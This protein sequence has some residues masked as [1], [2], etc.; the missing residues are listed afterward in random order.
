MLLLFDAHR[1]VEVGVPAIQ[2]WIDHGSILS[3][4]ST[5]LERC[6]SPLPADGDRDVLSSWENLPEALGLACRLPFDGPLAESTREAIEV[7][8]LARRSTG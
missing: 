8:F 5:L 3:W 6:G 4:W 1:H 2:E 7:A